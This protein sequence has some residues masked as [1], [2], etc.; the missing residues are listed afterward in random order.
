LGHIHA[1]Q[2]AVPGQPVYYAGNLQ[3][4]NPRETGAKGGLVV[5]A[6]A[7]VPAEPEFVRFA[8][9]RWERLIVDELPDTPVASALVG[10]LATRIDEL[11][12]RTDQLALRI[13]LRGETPLAPALRNPRELA[14]LEDEL[15]ARTGALEVQLRTGGVVQPVDRGALERSPTALALALGL[16]ESAARDDDLLD[17]LSPRELAHLNDAE[18]RGD[19]LRELLEDLPEELIERSLNGPDA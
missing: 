14:G 13:E 5:E 12:S 2:C 3:G 1:R 19:Y 11:G 16:I 10:H 18:K 15:A 6:R 4:R 7:G 8:P 9:I 17:E